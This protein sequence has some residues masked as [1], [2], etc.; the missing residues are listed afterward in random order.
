MDAGMKLEV[1]TGLAR[2]ADAMHYLRAAQER[3]AKEQT[4]ANVGVGEV[5]L[6]LGLERVLNHLGEAAGDVTPEM[7]I[8]MLS[9]RTIGLDEVRKVFESAA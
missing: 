7:W 5:C 2:L 8:A 3:I 1:A 6:A 4:S 9:E